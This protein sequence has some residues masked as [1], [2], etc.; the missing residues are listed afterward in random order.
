MKQTIITILFAIVWVAG[1]AQDRLILID[2]EDMAWMAKHPQMSFYNKEKA[3]LMIPQNASFGVECRP[4]FSTEWVLSYDSAAH[5]L[6]C[7]EAQESIWRATYLSSHKLKHAKRNHSKWVLR[8]HPKNYEA[9]DVKTYTLA[10]DAKQVG[11]LKAIWQNVI[12]TAE[13][14]EDLTLDGTTWEFFIGEQRAKARTDGYAVVK[15]AEQLAEVTKAGDASCCD[16]L[17]SA[18]YQSWGMLTTKE[19]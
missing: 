3:R 16:S 5:A 15:L 9:P 19:K 12:G 1:Q 10:I 2:S 11:M 17:I 6:I 7:N 14:R 18:S 8:K 13:K 4:S